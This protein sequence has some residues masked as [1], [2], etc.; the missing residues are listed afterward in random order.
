MTGN[1]RTNNHRS[2]TQAGPGFAYAV[3]PST[4]AAALTPAAMAALL[5]GPGDGASAAG[6]AVQPTLFVGA[7]GSG[8]QIALHT[9]VAYG[10]LLPDWVKFLV[11]D[12]AQEDLRIKRNGREWRMEPG[13]ELIYTGGVSIAALNRNLEHLPTFNQTFGDRLKEL[14]RVIIGNGVAGDRTMGAITLHWHAEAIERALM[15]N[16]RQLAHHDGAGSDDLAQAVGLNIVLAG[17]AC[18]GQGSGALIHLGYLVR[19]LLAELG[20]L[21]ENS[22][23]TLLALLPDSFP[24]LKLPFLEPN[25]V[26]FLRE[27]EH[28]M[29]KGGFRV[30][31]PNRREI[32]SLEAPYDRVFLLGGIDQRGRTRHSHSEVCAAAGEMMHLLFATSVGQKLW[33]DLVGYSDLLGQHTEG[34][35]LTCFGTLGLAVMAAD[36]LRAQQACARGLAASVVQEALL[37]TPQMQAATQAA[38]DFVG[39][40]DLQ[41]DALRRGLLVDADGSPN[42]GQIAAD[43]ALPGHIRRRAANEAPLAAIGYVRDYRQVYLVRQAGPQIDANAK[44]M[45]E[46]SLADLAATLVQTASSNGVLQAEAT[47]V[48]VRSRLGAEIDVW[49]QR[50][51]AQVQRQGEADEALRQAEDALGRVSGKMFLL[52]GAELARCLPRFERAAQEAADAFLDLRLTEAA[53]T[54]L[55]ALE[56]AAR[57]EE[58]RFQ[59]LAQRLHQALPLLQASIERGTGEPA[60]GQGSDLTIDIDLIDDATLGQL[61]AAYAPAISAGLAEVTAYAERQRLPLADWDQLTPGELADRL[62]ASL[63]APFARLANLGVE[64]VVAA[65]QESISP[66]RWQNRLLELAVPLCN[67]ETVRLVDGDVQPVEVTVLGVPDDRATQFTA[68]PEMLAATGDR[69]RV[70]ALAAT[71][72]LSLSALKQWPVWVKAYERKNGR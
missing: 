60:G 65:R 6:I 13:S 51:E 55:S 45:S 24:G 27:V 44:T 56:R 7:G 32:H 66:E 71:V 21:A 28:W 33:A 41:P 70:V 49:R 62:S 18:G 29:D 1:V 39:R 68:R 58:Q 19:G 36:G 3:S 9:K 31:F 63:Q 10:D 67:L 47:A 34:G 16:L 30:R 69:S 40:M 48:A 23:I 17:S 38:F 12:S 2:E 50:H 53:L 22:R 11:I 72:G 43:L 64:E 14:P 26:A 5:A 25:T 35:E 54:V 20:Q 59:G 4:P 52:Q 15:A 57:A 8:H 61:Y 42:G 46:R 37:A